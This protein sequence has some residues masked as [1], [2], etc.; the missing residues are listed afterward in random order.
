MEIHINNNKIKYTTS[1]LAHIQ[2]FR[3]YNTDKYKESVNQ[4][5]NLSLSLLSNNDC[6]E[7]FEYIKTPTY[8]LIKNNIFYDLLTIIDFL[9]DEIIINHMKEYLSLLTIEHKIKR[10]Q[11]LQK[12]FGDT[13]LNIHKC[14][15]L[16]AHILYNINDEYD[17]IRI[18][19]QLLHNYVFYLLDNINYATILESMF[20]RIYGYNDMQYLLN[21]YSNL[22]YALDP[23]HKHYCLSPDIKI[24]FLGTLENIK[25][26][27]INK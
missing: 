9:H 22:T 19:E 21:I 16:L 17:W 20:N 4:S 27:K 13:N 15:K 6:N 10:L 18:S 14:D 24:F 1:D 26:T 12:F 8:N 7:I 23:I 25:Y 5:I 2:Y 3:S 11:I